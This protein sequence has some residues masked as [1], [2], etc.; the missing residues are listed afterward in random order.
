[1]KR[2]IQTISFYTEGNTPE[3]SFEVAQAI[4]NEINKKDDSRRASIDEMRSQQ[5]GQIGSGAVDLEALKDAHDK[6]VLEDF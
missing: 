2:Y 5:F 4:C 6:K 1:M 3:E